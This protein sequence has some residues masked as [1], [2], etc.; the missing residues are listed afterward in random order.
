MVRKATLDIATLLTLGPE[1]L[2][3][4][5][6]DET[7]REA[8]FRK[9]VKAALAAT[10]GPEAVA[11]LIDRRLAALEKAKSF[12]DWQKARAFRDDLAA[13]LETIA[14]ELAT[15]SPAM[16]VDR[17]LRFLATHDSV[18]ER[19]DD[20]SGQVQTVYRDAVDAIGALAPKLSP[21]EADSLPETIM[22]R[23]GQSTYGYLV[24]VAQGVTGH[25]PPEA[26][27]RWDAVLDAGLRE[28]AAN[29]PKTRA[30][31]D[32]SPLRQ[33]SVVR[34][35]IAEARGDLDGFI[36][37]EA[38]KHPNLQD[39]LEIAERLLA[40]GR[41]EEALDWVRRRRSDGLRMMTMDDLADGA[42]PRD[43]FATQRTLLEALILDQ[44]G[45]RQEAQML[46]WKSFEESLDPKILRA[47]VDALADFEEF[48]VLDRAFAHVLASPQAY[49]ALVFFLEWPRLDHAAALVAA[50]A[51]DWDGRHYDL[52]APAADALEAAHPLAASILLRSLAEAIL[53]RANS[54]AYP[55]AARYL[56]RLDAL[57]SRV[58]PGD[59]THGVIA[60]ESWR[61]GIAQKH[62][63]KSGLW[64]LLPKFHQA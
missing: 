24:E 13:T 51:K 55:H 61:A 56:G 26:L 37:L 47:H 20:S 28:H 7:V 8:G 2:A 42:A 57:A 17:L 4:L 36:V 58:G 25:L 45:R 62:A 30:G 9:I 22:A 32:V 19:V 43:P 41:A 5:V 11:K 12:I 16:A 15:A 10:D 38:S 49:R 6:L 48:D 18:F 35:A 46:R 64:A 39:T 63:R 1:K 14:G 33:W 31:F 27:T 59:W 3:R 23:L 50:R 29:V 44:L 52:L 54:K 60:H 21:R 40:A 34:Q 53:D